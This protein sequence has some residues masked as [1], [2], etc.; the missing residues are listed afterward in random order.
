MWD[1]IKVYNL[2]IEIVSTK[3]NSTIKM[4]IHYSLQ[5]STSVTKHM[6]VV[7]PPRFQGRPS[8]LETSVESTAVIIT[9]FRVS[10]KML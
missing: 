7:E 10:I 2:I 5:N 8:I 1:Y 9:I 3:K 6:R 4:K